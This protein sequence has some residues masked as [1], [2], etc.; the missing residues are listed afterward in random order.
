MQECGE[1]GCQELILRAIGCV[2]RLAKNFLVGVR[3]GLHGSL[4]FLSFLLRVSHGSS[5]RASVGIFSFFLFAL[6]FLQMTNAAMS[7]TGNVGSATRALSAAAKR[8]DRP[9]LLR[10][11]GTQSLS[12]VKK[13]EFKVLSGFRG[14]GGLVRVG[15]MGDG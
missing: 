1:R 10:Q 7:T 9:T 3:I 15:D 5:F 12:I 13:I 2:Y 11:V 4:F 6:H 8:L 14:V